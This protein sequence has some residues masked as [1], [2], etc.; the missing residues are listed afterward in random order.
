[1]YFLNVLTFV[2]IVPI[3]TYIIRKGARISFAIGTISHRY[4]TAFCAIE[5]L[6][7]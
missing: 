2:K 7:P 3:Y 1:M 5:Y 6:Q 4:A